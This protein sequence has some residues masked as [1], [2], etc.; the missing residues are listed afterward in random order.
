M[1]LTQEQLTKAK[2]AKSVEELLALA[3]ENGLELTEEEA[4]N[5]FEQWHKEGELAD[6]E[7]NNVA[8]GACYSSGVWGPNGYQKYAVVSP[9]SHAEE[10]RQNG[11]IVYRE[12]G[13]YRNDGVEGCPTFCY[14]CRNYFTVGA[15]CYCGAR[16]EGHDPLE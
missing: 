14:Q 5:Y 12:D 16:W 4:K 7:L 9:L 6:E 2:A 15:T 3:K 1:K 10:C 8:G 11:V 13:C